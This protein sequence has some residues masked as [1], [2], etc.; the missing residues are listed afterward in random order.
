MEDIVKQKYLKFIEELYEC[1]LLNKM[2]FENWP[3]YN[4]NTGQFLSLS[5]MKERY[6]LTPDDIRGFGS[7][8]LII[9]FDED[10]IVPYGRFIIDLESLS[11]SEMIEKYAQ[12]YEDG[13]RTT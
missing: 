6:D 10:R 4:N 2:R 7:E 5:K 1:E 11:L 9:G 13:L 8:P 3:V 12:I